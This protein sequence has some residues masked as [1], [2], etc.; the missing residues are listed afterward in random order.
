MVGSTVGLTAGLN[1][2]KDIGDGT[3]TLLKIGEFVKTMGGR[4]SIT[5]A[6]FSFLLQETNAQVWSLLIVYLKNSPQ[7]ITRPVPWHSLM[8]QL[9]DTPA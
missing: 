4:V 5:K 8:T 2:G 1:M 9:T 3:K 6:G 7:V